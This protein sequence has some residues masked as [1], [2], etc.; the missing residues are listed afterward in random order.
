M[1]SFLNRFN[2][3]DTMNDTFTFIGRLLFLC[4]ELEV[5]L[6]F[7]IPIILFEEKGITNETN[8]DSMITF[9]KEKSAKF[10]GQ[11]KTESRDIFNEDD[12]KIIVS[13]I[14]ARNFICHDIC[15]QIR[16]FGGLTNITRVYSLMQSDKIKGI[17][18][19]LAL[20]SYLIMSIEHNI[21]EKEVFFIR[22]EEYIDMF[23]KFAFNN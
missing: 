5:S 8:F 17:V 15:E 2:K 11:L 23:I 21:T 7:V 9:L 20:G 22:K 6:K 14:E 19:D 18:N 10:I 1:N 13:A 12:Y 16:E 4:Q 3:I